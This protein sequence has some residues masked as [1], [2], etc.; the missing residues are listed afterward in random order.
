[1][2]TL[3]KA[4]MMRMFKHIFF[5]PGLILAF[6]ITIF[7]VRLKIADPD[8]AEYWH[9]SA[10]L[11]I[12]AFSSFFIPFFLGC[13]YKDGAMRNKVIAGRKQST[14]YMADLISALL[15]TTIMVV[16]WLAA[17]IIGL[18]S[19]GAPIGIGFIQNSAMILMVN[20]FYT[21]IIVWFS[22]RIKKMVLSSIISI[23]FFIVSYFS[24]VTAFSINMLSGNSVTA[25]AENL[26]PL[27]QWFG[28]MNMDD[29]VPFYVRIAISIA[30]L[31]VVTLIGKFK[32]NKRALV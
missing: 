22:L 15:G 31:I 11:G 30:L 12:A 7:V 25:V 9:R 26:F 6:L 17:G 32:I 14:V 21:A 5:I 4:N 29:S 24:G 19:G 16:V 23:L 8:V 28:I 13:E 2:N 1:M 20:L 18:V 27:G 10:S 3:V